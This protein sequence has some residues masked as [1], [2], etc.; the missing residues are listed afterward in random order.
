MNIAP[1]NNWVNLM[2]NILTASP[3]VFTDT[4]SVGVMSR[5]YRARLMPQRE[6]WQHSF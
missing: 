4:D 5:L 1:S 3:E 2:T 6:F